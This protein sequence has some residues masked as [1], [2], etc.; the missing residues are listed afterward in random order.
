MKSVLAVLF[1]FI[2][3]LF[4]WFLNAFLV[5]F[6][7]YAAVSAGAGAGLFLI[8][9]MLFIWIICPG[10]GAF[11]AVSATVKKFSDVQIQTIFDGFVTVCAVLIFMFFIFSVS[12]YLMD[13]NSFWNMVLF[14]LQSC[15][16]IYGSKFGKAYAVS[17]ISN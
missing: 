17:K 6:L 8:L 5:G 4:S 14:V 11:I 3:F 9:N 7:A 10:I 12:M 16:V 15:A 2:V 1:A 13:V